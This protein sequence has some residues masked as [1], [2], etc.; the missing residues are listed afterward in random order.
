MVLRSVVFLTVIFLPVMVFFISIG[1]LWII[2][3][4]VVAILATV[5]GG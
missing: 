4:S 5:D 2:F 1:K 3:L